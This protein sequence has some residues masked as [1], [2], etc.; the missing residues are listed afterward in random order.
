MAEERRQDEFRTRLL[1]QKHRQQQQQRPTAAGPKFIDKIDRLVGG[2]QTGKQ[3]AKS[4]TADDDRQF[5]FGELP[6]SF[7]PFFLLVR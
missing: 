5:G 3:A 1:E 2:R 4:I 7:L 6:A